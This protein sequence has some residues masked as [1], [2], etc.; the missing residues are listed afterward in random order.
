MKIKVIL[1]APV[2]IYLNILNLCAQEKITIVEK[3][4]TTTE[5]NWETHETRSRTSSTYYFILGDDRD[6]MMPTG[7]KGKN[8]RPHIKDEEALKL[9]DK[10]LKQVRWGNAT[11]LGMIGGAGLM[12]AG[13]LNS[14]QKFDD[15]GDVFEVPI[16]NPLMIS[17]SIITLGSIIARPI[18]HKKFDKNFAKSIEMHN[19]TVSS[20][21]NSNM[22]IDNIG[23]TL[24][25]RT[26]RPQLYLSWRF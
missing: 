16:L 20:G 8:L 17:G 10:S 18:L 13:G 26:S 19:N 9:F 6:N 5:R 4:T 15:Q 1:I 25:N 24:D 21:S 14:G 3:Q 23:L 7:K 2:I 11:F 22:R 12:V